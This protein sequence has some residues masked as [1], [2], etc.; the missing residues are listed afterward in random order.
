[1]FQ[2]LYYS[3]NPQDNEY[4]TNNELLKTR[5]IEVEQERDTYERKWRFHKKCY[6]TNNEFLKTRIIEVERERDRYERKW[7]F[8]K[9][10]Y[11][12]KCESFNRVE[13]DNIKLRQKY[14][15]LQQK[16]EQ[17][18]THTELWTYIF[19]ILLLKY[20]VYDL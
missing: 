6:E 3:E 9:K 14:F 16:Y 20:L 8:H 4:E 17:Y 12:T 2:W 5:I 11:E 18:Y 13:R 10:C 1:M 15:E 19:T 7:R